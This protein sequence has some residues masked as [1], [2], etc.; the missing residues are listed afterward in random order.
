M[1]I[2]LTSF[3]GEVP[4][5]SDKL[6][7]DANAA[8][9]K[10]CDL[11]SGSL[12]QIKGLTSGVMSIG[13]TVAT[14]FRRSSSFLTFTSLVN[15]VRSFVSS[16]DRLIYTGDG[17]PKE[18]DG[19][20]HI[21]LGIEAPTGA[22]TIHLT[23]TAGEDD[24]TRDISY[25]YTRVSKRADGSDVESAPS[26]PTAVVTV[27]SSVS[28]AVS[29]F[30]VSGLPTGTVVSHYRLYRLTAGTTGA[31]YQ[32][33]MEITTAQGVGEVSD[34]VSDSDLS[35]EVL[36]TTYWTAPDNTL[37][38][39]VATSHGML[40]GFVG[41]RVYP[42]EVFIPYA[43]PET[44]SMTV[45]SDVVALGY[46]GSMV[47]VL[48]ETVPYLLYGQN[49]ETLELRRLGHPQP[50]VS[51]RS[52]VNIPGGVV[53]AAP[54]GLFL[55]NEAGQGT[56]LTKKLFTRDQWAAKGPENI[57]AFYYDESYL[58][59]FS[60]AKTGFQI[61]LDTGQYSVYEVPQNIYGGMYSPEDDKLYLIQTAGAARDIASWRTGTV[62]DYTWKSK[63]FSFSYLM[64]MSAG[65]VQGTFGSV[66]LT[67][68]VDGVAQTPITITD[69]D[70]FR[71]PPV[72][73]SDFQVL[74]E[75]SASL[76]RVKIGQ[77]M[78]EVTN[79]E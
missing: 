44:Y 22:L 62:L 79:G 14:I 46:T 17:Y 71:M 49:P 28:V 39:L 77:S 54:D 59:F 15:I 68:Y 78:S 30:S 36:Q 48:T 73:G 31:E 10:N 76:D 51:A 61:S 3:D 56:L 11:N 63:I 45:E 69:D 57:I 12:G 8:T 74:L 27:A 53:Y 60:G 35:G 75:G 58:C 24:T 66:G 52:V 65:M 72:Q 1:G 26:P 50:C 13:A 5:L 18:Y 9:A 42:S 25:V 43:F 41:N 40:Y 16:S 55:I 70:V 29:G 21:R 2:D 38:G 33:V 32:F 19:S 67:L 23:G 20:S 37:S 7:P 47:V 4:R 6:L 34:T 64:A